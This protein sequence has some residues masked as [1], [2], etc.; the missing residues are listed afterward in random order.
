MA[1]KLTESDAKLALR[2]HLADKAKTARAKH[3]FY[4][5]ADTI[6]K[7]LS[8]SALVRYPTGVRLDASALQAG[9]FAAVVPLGDHPSK[10][11]CIF[12]H[13][14]LEAR[15]ELWPH[16]IAYYIPPINYGDMA[17]PEDCECFG[18]TLLGIS[19]DEYYDT[20]CELSDSL[21]GGA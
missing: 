19:E 20:L 16:V 3:G 12:L 9:E 6:V 2:D 8:D 13:P 11:F 4:I 18:A 10:G 14:S 1:I 17:S 5:D 21:G 15:R 7:M